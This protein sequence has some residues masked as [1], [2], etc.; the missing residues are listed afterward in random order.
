MN[1]G[2]NVEVVTIL[3]E[4]ILRFDPNLR[5]YLLQLKE[6]FTKYQLENVLSLSSFY[7]IRIY[8][9]CKQYETIKERTI[10]IKELKEILDI[11]AKSYNIYNRFK[12]K[13][14]TIAEREIN[15]KT[16]ISIKFDISVF[17]LEITDFLVIMI[18]KSEF[19]TVQKR[20]FYC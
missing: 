20:P 4:I 11:K 2:V 3:R 5:P 17:Y 19:F 6:N 16:D 1:D 18:L 8:E 15:E 7:A 13:V 9:L 10:E 12:E 14:L